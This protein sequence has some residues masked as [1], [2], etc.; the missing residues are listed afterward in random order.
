MNQKPD[1]TGE[2]RKKPVETEDFRLTK[3]LEK[4]KVNGGTVLCT[5]MNIG[6]CASLNGCFS[7]GVPAGKAIRPR[8]LFRTQEGATHGKG[9]DKDSTGSPYGGEA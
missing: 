4:A 2:N 7:F 5:R 1:K 3:P 8:N 9:N 6:D